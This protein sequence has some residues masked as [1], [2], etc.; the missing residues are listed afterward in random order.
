MTNNGWYAI[1]PNQNKLNF[2]IQD[3][4]LIS[5]LP[6]PQS[7][8]FF[9]PFRLLSWLRYNCTFVISTNIYETFKI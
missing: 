7:G 5:F 6:F 1:K 9:F 8:D 3:D 4:L 2:Y